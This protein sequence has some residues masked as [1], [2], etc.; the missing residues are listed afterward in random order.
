VRKWA[1]QILSGLGHLHARG[2]AHGD[3]RLG[4]VFINGET[5]NV[6]LGAFPQAAV[7]AAAEG[8]AA[9][10][11]IRYAP[12]EGTPPLVLLLGGAGEAGAAAAATGAGLGASA[13]AMSATSGTAAAAPSSSAGGAGG[14]GGA[15]S[16]VMAAATATP[17][18]A[19]D[20]FAFGMALLEM[21]TRRTPHSS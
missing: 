10:R 15:P 19:G 9:R 12:P 18:P 5:G 8:E 11:I 14:A 13:D 6:L 4:S 21:V 3:I 1:R 16:T 17:T 20:V 2:R 7:V